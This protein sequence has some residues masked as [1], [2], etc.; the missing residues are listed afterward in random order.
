MWYENMIHNTAMKVT[1]GKFSLY[2]DFGIVTVVVLLCEFVFKGEASPSIYA[3]WV[4]GK[5]FQKPNTKSNSKSLGK[6]W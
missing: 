3:D 5:W 2:Q 1:W 6:F 4:N